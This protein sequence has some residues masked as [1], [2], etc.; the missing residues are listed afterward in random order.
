MFDRAAGRELISVAPT[1][2]TIGNV[3]RRVLFMIR[4]EYSNKVRQVNTWSW[5]PVLIV[6]NY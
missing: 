2:L 5:K 1:E 3:V 6:F 4:E